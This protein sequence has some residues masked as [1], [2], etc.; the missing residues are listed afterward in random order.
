MKNKKFINVIIISLL[1]TFFSIYRCSEYEEPLLINEPTIDYA[2]NPVI[3]SV[4][5]ADSAIAGVRQITI[6]GENFLFSGEDSTTYVYIGGEI[7]KIRTISEDE[8]VLDRPKVYGDDMAISIMIPR[9]QSVAQVDY[10]IERP[11]AP[12]SDFQYVASALSSFAI[13]PNEDLYVAASRR[14]YHLTEDGLYLTELIYLPSAF[15]QMTDIKLGPEGYLYIARRDE[16]LY[17]IDPTA[18]TPEEEL[19]TELSEDVNYMDFDENGNLYCGDR[20]G[21]WILNPDKTETFSGHHD[22]ITINQIR[23]FEGYVYVASPKAIFRNI[24]L[25]NTG[26]LGESEIVV[27]LANIPD[28]ASGDITSFAIDVNGMIIICL[29]NIPGQSIFL[30]EEDGSVNPYYAKKILPVRVDQII[31]GRGRFIYL[32]KGISILGGTAT[33][34]SV[35]VYKM[36]MQYDGAPYL[37]Y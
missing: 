26:S 21:V 2:V 12:F 1:I 28:L 24:I 4:E 22:D 36:G 6:Q 14:I 19:Y 20:D 34:D 8:I 30:L 23:V 15:R 11:V 18:A 3:I 33:A 16:E 10:K 32:N 5:P 29:K 37:G 27:D 25:D 35:R 7:A 9:A 17:R 31:Y 13:A